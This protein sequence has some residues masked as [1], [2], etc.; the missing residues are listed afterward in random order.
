MENIPNIE[1]ISNAFDSYEFMLLPHGGQSLIETLDKATESG[2]RFDN[3]MER[4][5]LL[6]SFRRIYSEK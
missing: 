1:Q 6:Q 3:S 5:Y 2:H 4:K